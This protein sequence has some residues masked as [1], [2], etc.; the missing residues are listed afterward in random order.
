MAPTATKQRRA[1]GIV[2]VSQV[3]GRQGERFAS[4]AEQRQRIEVACE[5]DGLTLLRIEDEP[6]VSGGTP[7]EHRDKLRRAVQAVEAADAEVIIV[8]YFYRLER[9]LRVQG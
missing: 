3:G 2:R 9:S 8:A 7:L 1:I 5:R 4:P 6:N